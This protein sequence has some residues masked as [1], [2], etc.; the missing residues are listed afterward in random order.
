MAEDFVYRFRTEGLDELTVKIKQ[1]EAEF[2]ASSKSSAT[3]AKALGLTYG[4]AQKLAQGIGLSASQM[5]KA[6]GLL[7]QLGNSGANTQQRFDALNKGLGVTAQQFLSL[8]KAVNTQ[9]ESQ[10]KLK[11]QIEQAAIAQKSQ[12]E[13]NRQLADAQRL[14]QVEAE[15][16]FQTNAKLA[17]QRVKEESKAQAVEAKGLAA[18]QKAQQV[19][20]EKIFQ[21][22]AKLTGQRVKEELTAQ[23]QA[24]RELTNAQKAQQAEAEKIFQTN[25]RLT[26][27][28]VKEDLARQKEGFQAL[29]LAAAGAVTALGA[30]AVKGVKEFADFDKSIRTFG[31]VTEST[32][33]GGLAKLRSEIERLSAATTKSPQEIAA[34]SVELGKAG[35]SAEKTKQALA[36]VVQSSEATG[37]GLARTGEVIGTTLNQFGLSADNSIKIADLLT[38]ASNASAAGTND[39]GE[40]LSYVGAQA[41]ASNQSI[42]DTVTTI[43]LLANGG[44]KGSAAGTGL[45]EALRRLKLASA[46]ATTELTDLRSRGSKNAIAA[47]ERLNL[48]VR[49]SAGNLKPFPEI[50]QSIKGS[51]GS[52]DQGNKDLLLNALFGVQGG[53]VVQT[54]LGQTNGQIKEVTDS[55]AKFEG[56]S[57]KASKELTQGLSGSLTILGSSTELGTQ[58]IGQF[59][60]IGLEPLVRG[61]TVLI[62]TFVALPTPIQGAIVVVGALAGALAAAVAVVTAFELANGQL[63]VTTALSAG[64]TILDTIATNA[65]AAAKLLAAAATG[66]LTVAQDESISAFLKQAAVAGLLAGAIASIALAVDTFQ[67][68]GRAAEQQKQGVDAFSSAFD[69]L[70]EAQ[71]KSADAST[72]ANAASSL[73]EASNKRIQDSIGGIQQ[74]LDLLRNA[75]STISLRNLLEQFAKLE[76]VPKPIK[77]LIGGIVNFLP[78]VSTAAEA[79]ANN[80]KIAFGEVLDTADKLESKFGDIFAKGGLKNQTKEELD[81]LS[82]ATAASI[83][84]I[85]KAAPADAADA[86]GKAVRIS[87]L[88]ELQKQLEA[89]GKAESATGPQANNKP[90]KGAD[91]SQKNEDAKNQGEDRREARQDAKAKEDA[92]FQDQ[93]QTAK[94]KFQDDDRRKEQAFNDRKTQRATEFQDAQTVIEKQN[95]TEKQQREFTFQSA[96]TTIE[97][98]NQTDKQ[99]REAAFQQQQQQAEATFKEGQRQRDAALKSTQTEA[100][101]QLDIESAR[102]RDRRKLLQQK[103]T[104]DNVAKLSN[105]DLQGLT[106]EA[107]A[108]LAK[109]TAGVDNV[110][111]KR[112]AEQAQIALKAI[113]DRQNTALKEKERKEDEAFKAK[114]KAEDL[115]FKVA[116]EAIDAKKETEK[117]AR[118]RQFKVEQEAIDAQ[119]ETEK[120]ARDRQFKVEQ[121]ALDRQH[122]TEKRESQR[123]FESQQREVERGFKEEQRQ[124]DRDNAEEIKKIIESAKV[125]DSNTSPNKDAIPRFAG[126]GVTSGTTYAVNE[127]GPELIRSEGNLQWVGDGRPGL[128]RFKRS[129]VIIPAHRTQSLLNQSA[130]AQTRLSVAAPVSRG[131]FGVSGGSSGN[132]DAVVQELVRL[133]SQVELMRSVNQ[134]YHIETKNPM[135][136]VYRATK[137]AARMKR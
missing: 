88:K 94:Q 95:Q 66:Q 12:A 117:R 43:A 103:Q 96:Q 126:G 25:A 122:E 69:R 62:N 41:K 106:P 4:E 127:R 37:E 34:V 14:Q 89:T 26:G 112:D 105:A 119:K 130:Q 114:Q 78:K 50:I 5:Q 136:E 132:N 107:L 49:D 18:A 13:S 48:A 2:L 108:A 3:L 134:T 99:Q 9:A 64:K 55:M 56:A 121:D 44:I 76:A 85:E 20:A 74:A 58:K 80:S 77:D 51:L 68:V 40:A 6:V 33:T 120:R 102:G 63:A 54:L 1:M 16:I 39:L 111:N 129:G 83:S 92:A 93:Q 115:K 42:E 60:G 31:V 45:A 67:S 57:A 79:A 73:E 38:Q 21:T 7:Q 47:F 19:E 123:Q 29:G 8:D 113:T 90:L 11:T 71:L 22:N 61:A 118:D 27:Q 101:Q 24:S 32:G 131:T 70:S 30:I 98:Q 65:N 86:K 97:K 23:A 82:A 46:G 135:D 91:K 52:L 100:G 110:R 84:A 81:A 10:S 128:F 36:G 125:K 124:R 28:N 133:R 137:I 17:G 87:R 75:I 35:F 15:K 53:R 116:Q 72:K 104:Q 59:L 109:K